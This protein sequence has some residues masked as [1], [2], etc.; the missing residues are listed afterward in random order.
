MSCFPFVDYEYADR[1]CAAN[2][3]KSDN[4]GKH[5]ES[6]NSK[7]G[8]ENPWT[9]SLALLIVRYLVEQLSD[10]HQLQVGKAVLESLNLESLP[11]VEDLTEVQSFEE[12]CETIDCWCYGFDSITGGQE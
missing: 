5:V 11:T 2:I 7:L 12:V 4:F 9:R 3:I 6:I 10:S 1:T 8:D